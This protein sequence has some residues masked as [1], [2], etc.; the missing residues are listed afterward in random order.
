MKDE[1][2]L[3]YVNLYAI[4][5]VLPKLCELDEE[6][7]ALIANER[8][9]VGFAVRGGPEATLVFEDGRCFLREGVRGCKIKLPFSSPAKFNGMIDGT[10]TPIPSRGFTRIGFL[11]RKFMPLTD[12]LNAYLRAT[13][14]AL[15]DPKFFE[16][17]TTLMLYVI[18]GAVAQL[19]NHDPVSRVSA[20]Y[21][22]D[23]RIYLGIDGGA[24]ATLLADGQRLTLE[25]ARPIEE[26]FSYMRFPDL[27]TARDLFDGKVNAV[28]C[29]GLGQIRVGG[30]ISQVDNV[31]RI[32]DRV[33]TYLA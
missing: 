25:E 18:A 9:S 7:R 6:A 11:L 19:G 14:E 12:R 32:L 20:S 21:I 23:G 24:A 1:R 27:A 17:S 4:L 30:M 3:A 8:V 26:C 33:A 22:V 5:G 13:P 16:I 2:A 28:A 10:V 29:V 15:A 31:N